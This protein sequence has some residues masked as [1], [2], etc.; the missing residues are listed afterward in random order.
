[1]FKH[2]LCLQELI[3]RKPCTCQQR[4]ESE[5]TRCPVND[6]WPRGLWK[7][8]TNPYKGYFVQQWKTPP[9]GQDGQ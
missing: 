7:F 4:S 2:N 9:L 3:H 6:H 5:D 8:V 1:M